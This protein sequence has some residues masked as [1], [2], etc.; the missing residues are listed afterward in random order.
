MA[1]I[2][3]GRHLYGLAAVAF[4]IPADFPVDIPQ[5]IGNTPVDTPQE[6]ACLVTRQ[7]FPRASI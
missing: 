6:D 2:Y 5:V 4:G 1:R 7:K 3:L